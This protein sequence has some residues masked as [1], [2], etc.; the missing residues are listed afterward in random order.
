MGCLTWKMKLLFE[1]NP[2][3]TL[4]ELNKVAT[5]NSLRETDSA[6]SKHLGYIYW[7]LMHFT[8]Y[9]NKTQNYSID[10]FSPVF[11]SFVWGSL[12]PE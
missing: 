1:S 12:L 4:K 6:F 8:K 7:K 11:K 5:W 10:F 3:Y 9:T 2:V